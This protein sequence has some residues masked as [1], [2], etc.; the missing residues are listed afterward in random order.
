MLTLIRSYIITYTI[1]TLDRNIV[2]ATFEFLERKGYLS[3]HFNHPLQ[4]FL[5]LYLPNTKF[6][7]SFLITKAARLKLA[8]NLPVFLWEK[9]GV[10]QRV[11]RF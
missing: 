3:S 1:Y 11:R 5:F 4:M 10:V 9:L 6:E 8:Y 2:Q 7:L